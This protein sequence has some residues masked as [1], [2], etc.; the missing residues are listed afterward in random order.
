MVFALP[1]RARHHD[2]EPDGEGQPGRDE[3]QRDEREQECGETGRRHAHGDDDDLRGE[4]R[5]RRA[6]HEHVGMGEVDEFEDAV[7]EVD[8]QVRDRDEERLSTDE[9]IHPHIGT[10]IG[11]DPGHGAAVEGHH[12]VGQL[13]E[14]VHVRRDEEHGGAL[15]AEGEDPAV[16]LGAGGDVHA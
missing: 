3:R 13:D 16:D 1:P 7:D 6:E 5:E 8:G 4:E 10:R 9:G 11:T 2:H 12:S 15:V 14:L